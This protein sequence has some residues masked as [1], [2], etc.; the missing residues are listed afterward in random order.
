M[1]APLR[2]VFAR[3]AQQATLTDALRAGFGADAPVMQRLIKHDDKGSV[4]RATWRGRAVI[5]KQ[6]ASDTPARAIAQLQAKHDRLRALFPHQNLHFAAAL[7]CAPGQ[8][9]VVLPEL[10]GTRIDDVIISAPPTKRADVALAAARWF[11]R[12]LGPDRSTG[13]FAPGY[14]NNQLAQEVTRTPLPPRDATLLDAMARHLRALAPALQGGPVPR[15]PI[16]GDY[17]PQNIL[18]D[19]ATG[20]LGVFDVQD[21]YTAPLAQDLARLLVALSLGLI[22]RDPALPLDR[23]L[24]AHLRGVVMGCADLHHP[25]TQGGF[26]DFTTGYRLAMVLLRKHDHHLGE[27]ARHAITHWLEHVPCP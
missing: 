9:L 7:A 17:M 26:M 19:D 18:W 3:R 22:A 4:A 1:I 6:L 20:N 23:G 16:H 8:G 10:P 11:A 24:C 12:A 13:N 15:G 2:A 5:V 21:T 27:P 25:D 14:W